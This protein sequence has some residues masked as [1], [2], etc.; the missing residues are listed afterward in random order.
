MAHPPLNVVETR[1]EAPGWPAYYYRNSQGY[2]CGDTPKHVLPYSG[3]VN[4][5]MSKSAPLPSGQPTFVSAVS[6]EPTHSFKQNGGVPGSWCQPVINKAYQDLRQEALGDGSQLGVALAEWRQS[7]GLIGNGVVTMSRA[8]R[9]LRKFLY[10]FDVRDLLRVKDEVASAWLQ[11]WFGWSA[12]AS[13]VYGAM[14]ALSGDLS[15]GPVEG[16]SS[17][18]R[19]VPFKNLP[20]G[21]GYALQY[22]VKCG[23]TA[24]LV[25]PNLALLNQVGLVNPAAIVWELAPW[26]FVGDW[27]FDVSSFINSFT[28]WIGFNVTGAYTTYFQKSA[29]QQSQRFSGKWYTTGI[30]GWGHVRLTSL[31]RP[32]PNLEISANLGSSITRAASA[33]SLLT[34]EISRLRPYAIRRERPRGW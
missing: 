30:E 20:P 17:T 6:V 24:N 14:N 9:K 27:V 31:P 3:I 1:R 4:R 23:A 33:A 10:R 8:A 34:Q 5:V 15:S 19:W 26:S 32:M 22:F 7:W 2:K 25:N 11:F 18:A 28:D 29:T 21:D 16:S 13:D 12:S